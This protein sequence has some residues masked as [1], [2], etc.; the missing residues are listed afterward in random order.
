LHPIKAVVTTDIS[1]EASLTI[2]MDP[3][4]NMISTIGR[5]WILPTSTL[6]LAFG[7]T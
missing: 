3:A 5:I 1:T 2:L 4:E 6:V 7:D